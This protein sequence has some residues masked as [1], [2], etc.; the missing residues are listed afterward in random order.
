MS[1]T[2][3]DP[4]SL[5]HLF[6][7]AVPPP[8]PWWP[9]APGWF[10]VGGVVL[11]LGFWGAWRA[12][13]RWRA[14]AYRRAALAEW[15]QLKAQAADSGHR[16]IALRH[17]PELVKRV[18]LAAFPREAVASLSGETWLRF[19]PRESPVPPWCFALDRPGESRHPYTSQ[20]SQSW[21]ARSTHGPPQSGSGLR[22]RRSGDSPPRSAVGLSWRD[23]PDERVACGGW[24]QRCDSVRYDTAR[25]VGGALGV[26]GPRAVIRCD[27]GFGVGQAGE[28]PGVHTLHVVG[29]GLGFLPLGAGIRVGLLLGQLTRTH[30][31]KA[32]FLLRDCPSLYSTSTAAARFAHASGEAPRPGS[33]RAS[34]PIGARRV[35]GAPRLRVPDARHRCA[36]LTSLSRSHAPNTNPRCGDYRP[37]YPRQSHG[38]PPNPTPDTPQS[39]VGFPHYRCGCH[40]APRCAGVLLHPRSRRD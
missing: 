26:P 24:R 28:P 10:V 25:G 1:T 20:G 15:R 23:G 13:R 12:W 21:P 16:E 40:H 37:C 4:T 31:D 35:A 17:L 29:H 2:A 30:D 36:G 14:A 32:Q 19:D 39:P 5:E 18:A 8:V 38:P 34:P 6:D 11:G 22:A 3:A 9:P 27:S 7:L 33:A